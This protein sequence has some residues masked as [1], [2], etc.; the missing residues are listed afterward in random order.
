MLASDIVTRVRKIVGDTDVLQFDDPTILNWILD[1]IRECAIANNLLQATATSNTAVGT[2]TYPL[3]ADIAKLHSV[4]YNNEKLRNLTR[5]EFDEQYQTDGTD[6]GTPTTYFVWASN[7]NLF[8]APDSVKQLRIDYIQQ[9]ADIALNQAPPI[10]PIYHQR[11]VD[12]C[13]AQVAQQDDDLN[14]YQIKMQEF[15][16]G[17]QDL[18]EKDEIPVDAYPYISV[19]SRDMGDGVYDYD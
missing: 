2:A 8:P 5:E 19:D 18:K 3:P 16:S 14:R 6:Q 4:K 17:V 7:L 15:Q 10:P 11:L 1:G 12:Y 9:P 13:L